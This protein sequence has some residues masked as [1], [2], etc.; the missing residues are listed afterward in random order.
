[1]TTPEFGQY[2]P[3]AETTYIE[4]PN[5]EIGKLSA[6][7]SISRKRDALPALL[8]QFDACVIYE[9]P[10]VL[11]INKPPYVSTSGDSSGM[12][13]AAIAHRWRGSIVSPVHR[14]DKL[15]SGILLLG[16]TRQ[17]RRY[18]SKQFANPNSPALQKTY[19][20]M[21]DGELADD[22][23]IECYIDDIGRRVTVSDNPSMGK[24]SKTVATKIAEVTAESKEPR[25][26]LLV[27]TLT[28]RMHQIR[29]SLAK[30]GL[31]I[32][33][34]PLYGNHTVGGRMRLHASTLQFNHPTS[35]VPMVLSA[36]LP[37]DFFLGVGTIDRAYI[38]HA[39][40][41]QTN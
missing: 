31:P 16:K 22:R 3:N 38:E 32:V 2:R 13:I 15:T 24:H 4:S 11:A 21:V 29:V 36:P 19:L 30:I 1:M 28:G 8:E 10:A 37:Q 33:D 34:D 23:Y 41:S 14:L 25:S 12:D 17:A 20:A 39:V 18:L 40:Y 26:V 35:K 9:D 7:Q 6:A 5:I 27:Q